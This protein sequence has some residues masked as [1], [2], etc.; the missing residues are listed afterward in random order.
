MRLVG[1]PTTGKGRCEDS[2]AGRHRQWAAEWECGMKQIETETLKRM[3]RLKHLQP[4]DRARVAGFE[5]GSGGYRRKLLAMGLTPGTE[6]TVLRRAPLGDPVEIRVRGFDLS[7]RAAEADRLVIEILPPLAPETPE[8]TRRIALAGNPNCGKT[9]VFNALTGARHRV[10]NWPGVTVEKKTGH[11]VLG[12]V[13]VEVIDLPGVYTLESPEGEGAVDER[14]A[15]DFILSGQ[16]DTVVDVVD[17]ANLERNLYLTLQLLEMRVPVVVVLNMMDLLRASGRELDVPALARRLGCPV[18]PVV[19]ATGEGIDALRALLAEPHAPSRVQFHYAEPIEDAVQQVQP[20]LDAAEADP[21]WL[22]LGLLADDQAARARAPEPAQTQ[23]RQLAAKIEQTAG[24][25][26]DILVADGRYG[27]S[28]E[29]AREVMHQARPARRHRLSEGL[30]RV[31]LNRV[32]GLPVFLGAMYLMFLFTIKLGRVF[33]LFVKDLSQTL[34]IDGPLWS[35]TQ[36]GLPEAWVGPLVQ[37]LGNGLGVV[38]S[39]VPIIAFLYLFLAVLEDSGYMA[40]AA[41]VVDRLMRAVGLPGKAL[42][43]MIVGFG[44]NVPAVMG[45]RTLERQRDRVLAI[46]M[47]PFISCA[48]RLP[49]YV[50]FADVFF[51]VHGAAVVF[52]LYLIG[53][54]MAVLT[55]LVLRHTLLAAEPATFVMELPPYHLPRAGNVLLSTWDRV[56]GFVIKAGRFI[57]P[58]V[59]LIHLLNSLGTDGRYY[60][61]G[62][63]H[64]VLAAAGRAVTPVLAPMGIRQDN[65]PATVAL[66]TGILHKTVI[67]GTMEAIYPRLDG[68]MPSPTVVTF[69]LGDRLH[70]A[71]AT[72]PRAFR[73][74]FLPGGAQMQARMAR[75]RA[76]RLAPSLASRFDGWQGAMAFLLFVLLYFP[77]ITTN[78][79]AYREAGLR[80]SGFMTLWNTALA[81]AVGVGFY[82]IATFARHPVG[83]GAWVGG[84]VLV[85]ALTLCWMH[86]VGLRQRRQGAAVA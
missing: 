25:A 37:G 61:Q 83:A 79:A 70:K 30:D 16:V 55:A 44:C 53:I 12:A 76:E 27:M 20:L 15:R 7:L 35:L 82:Q 66:M 10:G 9:T 1:A 77:C 38:A 65:W 13:R 8:I 85:Y 57:V 81:Y 19:G 42:V 64:S 23:A 41:F 39:F 56:K 29:F 58:M 59:L 47:N 75:A 5:A 49:V 50:L 34:F 48:A 18:L 11:F 86:R 4:G 51:P 24:E 69:D 72:I 43:P 46:L 62:S 33:K 21:R 17:A 71:V 54:G 40:R 67:V 32:L 3:Q 26:A 78:A 2:E 6:F 68:T 14:I 80:W 28:H 63:E 73:A 36:L 52:G 84:A 60:P 74:Q 31:V 45:T 22:A